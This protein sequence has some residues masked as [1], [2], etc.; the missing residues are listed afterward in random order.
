M[1]QQRVTYVDVGASSAVLELRAT[2][3]NGHAHEHAE[4]G[5]AGKGEGLHLVE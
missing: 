5:R 1:G 4:H 3:G 2:T